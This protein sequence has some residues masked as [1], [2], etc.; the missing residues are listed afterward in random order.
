[1]TEQRIKLSA[2]AEVNANGE[3]EIIAITEGEGN[4]WQFSAA[5]LQASVPL[6]NGVNCLVD[7]AGWFDQPSVMKLSGVSYGPT[8]NEQKKGVQVTLRPIGPL[9]EVVRAFGREM[10]ALKAAGQVTP[11]AGFSADINFTA[12]NKT[13]Q[14]ITRVNSL[15]LVL[16]PA[17]GGEFL[18]ALNQAMRLAS[19]AQTDSRQEVRMADNATL[20]PAPA[21]TPEPAGNSQKAQLSQDVQAI[22]T[23]LN[24]QQEQLKMAAEVEAMRA[25][26]LQACGHLLD[27][28]LLASKLPAPS[29]AQVRKQFAGKV[30]EPQEL[31]AAIDDARELV[32]QLTAN[33]TVQGPA[34]LHGMFSGDDQILAAVHDLFE[35]ARDPG[36]EKLK[37]HRLEGIRALYLGLTGDY[38]FHGEATPARA[39]FQHTT[40]SFPGLV[41]N[42]MNKAV[43]EGWEQYGLAGY[44][45]WENL[46]TKPEH[47]KD[48]KSVTW[49]IVGTVGDL[50]AVTEGDEFGELKTGDSP[51]TSS[52]VTYGGYVGITRRAIVNDETKKILLIPKRLGQA[53]IRKISKLVAAIFTDNSAVGPTLAD[54]GALFNSTA[55][56]T[57]GGHANLLTTALGTDFVAWDAAAAAV[58]NQN[59]L[60]ANEAG[61]YGTGDKQALN[62]NIILVPRALYAAAEALFVPRWAGTVEAAIAAKGGPSYGGFVK[63]LVVPNWTDA[64][65]WAAVCDP[66][67]APAVCIGEA[68]G[69]K[70]EVFIAGDE[71][72]PAMFANDELRIKVRHEVAVGVADYRPLH[73]S[74]VA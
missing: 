64:T 13:V 38:D 48:L 59:M 7:H 30:F 67:L 31:T 27:T 63:V 29:Q 26:R 2:K 52:F 25:I 5:A 55:V 42:A 40:A 53:G 11:N 46:I 17:R 22:Q 18:R 47:F 19:P 33:Q 50:P 37:V 44:N 43:I 57:A 12:T 60:V 62:P 1:M 28:G 74:N 49:T 23:L 70:P 15:D 8:W 4:G 73:K 6:W 65:D 35:V 3:F 21:T 36:M 69:I 20:T 34:R 54:T 56:T 41:K 45:W 10:L 32:A 71:L 24:V 14:A 68:F 72:S 51:E 66:R 9:A 58:Y 16:D 61:Y 39:M